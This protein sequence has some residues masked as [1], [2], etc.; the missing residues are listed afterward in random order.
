MCKRAVVNLL[1]L[2]RKRH[3]AVIMSVFAL[4]ACSSLPSELH[5][6]SESVMTDYLTFAQSKGQ[7]VD[8]V[9]LGGVIAKTENQKKRTRIEIVNLPIDSSGRP[10]INQEPQGRF[11]AYFDGYL[12][13]IAFS[14]GRLITVVGQAIGQEQGQVGEHPYLFPALD[15]DGYRLWKIEERVRMYDT[16]N[17]GY[18]CYS[19]NCRIPYFDFPQEGQ[20]IKQVR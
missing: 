13:P 3:F 15:G 20:V 8:D 17:Y 11:V 10:D 5:A 1:T 9:R 14:Q 2:I 12:E 7:V 4:A 18:P 6:N 16:S 19:V